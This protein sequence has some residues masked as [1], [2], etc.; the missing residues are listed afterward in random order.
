MRLCC[1][2]RV[3]VT[4]VRVPV[5]SAR[6]GSAGGRAVDRWSRRAVERWTVDQRTTER[7]GGRPRGERTWAPGGGRPS[8]GAWAA[9]G[10]GYR[11][12]F[13]GDW[14][15]AV[16]RLLPVA[17]WFVALWNLD[18]RLPVPA[19]PASSVFTSSPQHRSRRQ[20]LNISHFHRSRPMAHG[21]GE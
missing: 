6:R 1:A 4:V 16:G 7:S 18:A 19:D 15:L 10:G 13:L 5:L 21:I 9:V 14:V 12:G 20:G 3:A 17:C 2:R 11:L 8:G